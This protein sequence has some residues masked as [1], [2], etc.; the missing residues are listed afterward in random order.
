MD[1]QTFNLEISAIQLHCNLKIEYGIPE[2][3]DVPKFYNIT[4]LQIS[5]ITDIQYRQGIHPCR[6]WITK[7]IHI[8]CGITAAHLCKFYL[9]WHYCVKIEENIL[10]FLLGTSN[11]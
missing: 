1:E 8:L 4:T 7:M 2:I 3:Q 5:I 6:E 9:K 11:R 10:L